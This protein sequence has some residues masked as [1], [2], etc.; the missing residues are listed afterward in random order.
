MIA[1]QP[2]AFITLISLSDSTTSLHL[3]QVSPTLQRLRQLLSTQQPNHT[4][5]TEVSQP[6]QPNNHHTHHQHAIKILDNAS[7]LPGPTTK[8][9]SSPATLITHNTH[10]SGKRTEC[11]IDTLFTVESRGSRRAEYPTHVRLRTPIRNDTEAA[12][13]TCKDLRDGMGEG[14]DSAD[15]LEST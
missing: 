8:P 10:L 4:S 3:L 5:H 6:R 7:S 2:S 11:D 15:L 1:I 13:S 9:T 14:F 12:T